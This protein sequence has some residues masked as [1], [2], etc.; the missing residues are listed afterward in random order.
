ML[1]LHALEI[2]SENFQLIQLM[3]NVCHLTQM[4]KPVPFVKDISQI[5]HNLC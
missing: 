2:Y 3:K 1:L 5:R 4:L